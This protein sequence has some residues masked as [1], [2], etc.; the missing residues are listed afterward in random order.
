MF[1]A[2]AWR[3]LVTFLLWS[4][5]VVLASP[6]L[7][8]GAVE[9]LGTTQFR[10]ES[11]VWNATAST[12]GNIVAIR[13]NRGVYVFNAA[14][15]Q[16]QRFISVPF[17]GL[18]A[19]P[20]P[21]VLSPDGRTFCVVDHQG[22]VLHDTLI[23]Q[24][25]GPFAI[26][27][28]DGCAGMAFS[29]NGA[30]VAASGQNE[31][32][33]SVVRI[34]DLTTDQI[35]RELKPSHDQFVQLAFSADGCLLV[36]WSKDRVEMFDVGN[37]KRCLSIQL[38]EHQWVGGVALSPNGK[39]LAVAEFT[40]PYEGLGQRPER[41][42]TFERI[43]LTKVRRLQSLSPTSV[44]CSTKLLSDSK[45]I[46]RRIPNS[47]TLNDTQVTHD[48]PANKDCLVT[49]YEPRSGK[50]LARYTLAN[51]VIRSWWYTPFSSFLS[52]RNGAIQMRYTPDGKWLVAA[53]ETG[54]LQIWDAQTGEPRKYRKLQGWK[55]EDIAFQPNGRM[56]GLSSCNQAVCLWDVETEQPL[57][58]QSGHTVPVRRLSFSRDS[59]TLFTTAADVVHEW[60]A[61]GGKHRRLWLREA[62]TKENDE[63][64]ELS[65]D[66]SCLLR[67][68]EVRCRAVVDPARNRVVTTLPCTDGSAVFSAD[69]T[70]AVFAYTRYTS[71]P[72]SRLEVWDLQ[73]GRR[74]LE[75]NGLHWENNVQAL[76][77]DGRLL[78]TTSCDRDS[79]NPESKSTVRVWRLVDGKQL[80]R[81]SVEKWC[82]V[83]A[84][85]PDGS[86]LAM[87]GP[88][89]VDVW[90]AATGEKCFSWFVLNEGEG[91]TSHLAF[92]ANGRMLAA[93]VDQNG[94]DGKIVV[95]EMAT[96]TVRSEFK[97]FGPKVTALAFSPDS[98]TL[99]SAHE[100][101]TIL[102]WDPFGPAEDRPAAHTWLKPPE[103][104]ALWSRLEVH[105][106]PTA[107]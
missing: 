100:D 101:T 102:L 67:R 68:A 5:P 81:F 95:W 44:V 24:T 19:P 39:Q 8:S 69:G 59:S 40:F 89:N 10:V 49:V 35:I 45:T 85:S 57:T 72:S 21:A 42:R 36:A 97:D 41:D 11:E 99:A 53:M 78:A 73:T 15:G 46:Y 31:K 47:Q 2:I 29:A 77:A 17:V 63:W 6:P 16:R 76:S 12:D 87:G 37:G 54:G 25:R 3:A 22:L 55:L 71:P 83:L 26:G 66:A 98:R 28:R 20:V 75:Q 64:F 105:D 82:K 88:T 43:S 33:K 92:S 48:A 61:A 103:L 84:F 18:N 14:I 52:E 90:D 74:L 91:E 32:E 13:N 94:E 93:A 7:P 27:L 4:V 23:E 1:R 50:R 86:R 56:L 79:N 107:R 106:P 34:W 60:D 96:A 65:P 51:M 58:P 70:V 30:R 80:G 9:R 38:D 62:E 104:A